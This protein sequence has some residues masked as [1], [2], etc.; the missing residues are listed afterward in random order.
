PFYKSFS[1]A[2]QAFDKEAKRV[3]ANFKRAR[4]IGLQIQK[5][6][7]SRAQLAHELLQG[8]VAVVLLD[9]GRLGARE[10]RAV[11]RTQYDGWRE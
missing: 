10:L 1:D 7:V 9:G 11:P 5:R 3:A 2:P 8:R 6:R 4:K